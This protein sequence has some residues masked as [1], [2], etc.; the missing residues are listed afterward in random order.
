MGI[1]LKCK[2][3]NE[4]G[5]FNVTLDGELV[6]KCVICGTERRIYHDTQFLIQ[7]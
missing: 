4:V 3:C 2:K 1:K 7:G 6:L 5:V